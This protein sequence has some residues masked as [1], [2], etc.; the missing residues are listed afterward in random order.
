MKTILVLT[1]LSE[2]AANAT[3]AGALLATQLQADLLLFNAYV[4]APIIPQYAG[5]PWIMDEIAEREHMC[6]EKLEKQRNLLEGY[7]SV[8]STEP[9]QPIIHIRAGA[10]SLTGNVAEITHQRKI[11]M[12]ITGSRNGS[13]IDHLVGGSDTYAIIDKSTRPVL[14][15]PPGNEP[16]RFKK[17]I[18]ATDFEDDDITALPYL[19]KLAKQLNCK[20]EVV[21][22]QTA[23][24]G[25]ITGNSQLKTFLTE[26]HKQ[27]YPGITY[28]EIRGKDVVN[29][30]NTYCNETKADV[31]ALTHHQDS[32]LMRL[33]RNSTSK[34]ILTNQHVPL[35]VIPSNI[36]N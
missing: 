25:D 19:I 9:V 27:K 13:T 15:V 32:F 24:E 28:S 35:L 14:I 6:I 12:I 2:N 16:K 31:L 26:I 20:M 30:L 11:E 34:K 7:L 18:F 23:G 22:V 5:G 1:D 17:M 36:K 33:I 21:H 8:Q 29:R 4:T 3:R 10:G